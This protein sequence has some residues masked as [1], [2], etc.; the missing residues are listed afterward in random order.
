MEEEALSAVTLAA[1]KKSE[2]FRTPA[3]YF[4][5][6]AMAGCFCTIGMALA[7]SVAGGFYS[8]DALRGAHSFMLGA[9][10]TLSFTMI[11]FAGAELF[12]GNVLSMT[13]GFLQGK[14]RLSLCVKFLAVCYLANVLGA[15][16]MGLIV[17]SAGTLQGQ[18]GDY[19]L[20]LV[21]GKA[22]LSLSQGFFKGILCNTLVCLGMWC[23][24]KVKSESAKLIIL[25]WAVLGFVAPG[26]EHSIAN[27]GLFTMAIAA[28]SLSII[29][30]QGI[31][32]NML[33][34]TLGNLAGGSL[35]VGLV[36]WYSGRKDG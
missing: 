13:I 32:L 5:Y 33:T 22:S 8:S 16:F 3:R 36:Y 25:F 6:S 35:F 20:R 27:A 12:T 19:L 15:A 10:F 14:L 2:F 31:L 23:V 9:M 24:F 4:I 29:N 17:Y 7:C 28:N 30:L 18:T 1:L 21:E 26:Y 34:V 11:I